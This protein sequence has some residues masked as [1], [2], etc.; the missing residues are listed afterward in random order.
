MRFS[1]RLLCACM[2][3]V[4][5]TGISFAD[6]FQKAPGYDLRILAPYQDEGVGE[7]GEIAGARYKLSECQQ[8]LIVI[9]LFGD[10][11]TAHDPQRTVTVF[12]PAALNL[13]NARVVNGLVVSGLR[14]AWAHCFA[15]RNRNRLGQQDFRG[16]RVLIVQKN[17]LAVATGRT[18]LNARDNTIGVSNITH[19]LADQI[20]AREKVKIDEER[21]RQLAAEAE[22]RARLE[23]EQQRQRKA[24]A[25]QQARIQEEQDRQRE[26]EAEQRALASARTWRMITYLFGGVLAVIGFVLAVRIFPSLVARVRRYLNPQLAFKYIASE[27]LK[28]EDG[29]TMSSDPEFFAP[30]E[31]TRSPITNF[32]D[33]ISASPVNR[34]FDRFRRLGVEERRRLVVSVRDLIADMESSNYAVASYEKSRV[35]LNTVGQ[36]RESEE[37]KILTTLKIEENKLFLQLAESELV[38]F[39]AE[40][41]LAKRRN[42]PPPKE[43]TPG[44]DP[45]MESL[46]ETFS[47][48]GKYRQEALAMEDDLIRKRGGKDNL[49]PED[50]ERIKNVHQH[51][52]EI[53]LSKSR[54]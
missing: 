40:E 10:S 1:P 12:V 27:T 34:I 7:G 6:S 21:Q 36:L 5:A 3:Y 28:Q 22:Q 11:Y 18:Q 26:A 17:E 20:A 25:D 46:R 31:R 15:Q 2:A 30:A 33:N 50:Q 49:T 19:H 54:R 52:T 32:A 42:P 13:M 37:L 29:N 4:A 9:E 8:R 35:H 45:N 48:G 23:E 16:V 38:R 53:E 41:K 24:E 51:A 14:H 43:P 39:D 44:R 47:G